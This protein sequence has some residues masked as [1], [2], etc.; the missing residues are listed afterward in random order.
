HPCHA[1]PGRAPCGGTPG[2][3]RRNARHRRRVH[4]TAPDR[5]GAGAGGAGAGS[6]GGGGGGVRLPRR[7]DLGR[8]DEGR[9]RLGRARGGSGRGQRRHRTAVRSADGGGGRQGGGGARDHA[10]TGYAARDRLGC[11]CGLRWGHRRRGHPRAA[12]GHG[13]RGGRRDGRR[14]PRGGS[15]ARLL[16]DRGAE[17]VRGRPAR[18]LPVPWAPAARGSLPQALPGC[19]HRAGSWRAGCRD[20]RGLR[21]RMGAGRQALP[22]ARCP[23]HPR[24]ARGGPILRR[25]TARFMNDATSSRPPYLA[26]VVVALLVL[27]G[28]VL[29][30]APTVTF[31]DAG[32]FIAAARV[33]GIPHPPGTPLFVLIAHVW[34]TLIPFGEFAYRTN[35]LSAVLSAG[36]A[37]FFFLVAHETLATVART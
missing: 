30:L 3:R 29:T 12:R 32:E 5:A 26:A 16:Q 27:T 25:I 33:L 28:Y 13:P 22:R 8:H 20:G 24:C 23:C 31:W 37:G 2:R 19:C 17:Y 4:P 6:S 9:S 35:L 14:M 15:R 7:A 34:G 1:R 21:A 36:A 18:G 11:E 10:F